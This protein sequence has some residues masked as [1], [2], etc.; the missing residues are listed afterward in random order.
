MSLRNLTPEHI[1]N[2]YTRYYGASYNVKSNGT[3]PVQKG[4]VPKSYSSQETPTS[5]ME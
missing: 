3:N 2:F 4:L 5:D 1:H